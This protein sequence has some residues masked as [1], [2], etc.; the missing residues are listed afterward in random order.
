MKKSG[1]CPKCNSAQ[2]YTDKNETSRGDRS[3]MASHGKGFFSTGLFIQV[4]LCLDC[5][6]FEEYIREDDLKNQ[7][8]TEAIKS[9]W[10]R[11]S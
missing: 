9:N 2:V 1:I 8:K 4:C 11:V 7:K 3:V 10:D 5:G 6:Y